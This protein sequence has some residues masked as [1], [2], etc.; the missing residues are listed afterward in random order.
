[1]YTCSRLIHEWIHYFYITV[2]TDKTLSKVYTV[3]VFTT[4]CKGE[5]YKMI[6]ET[7]QAIVNITYPHQSYL[8]DESD[9]PY[10]KD[11]CRQLGG[12]HVTRIEKIN[13]KAGNIN[14]ALRQSNGELCVVLD[15]D[16]VP[17]PDFLDPI[18]GHFSDEKVGYVQIVQAYKNYGESLVAKGAAQQTFQFYGPIMMT[19]NKYG[20]V[21]AI[22]ANCTFRRTALESIGGHA[23]GLAEDMNT[24]MHL[25][26]KGWKSLYV[27]QVL[28]RGLVPSTMSAYYSQQL[29]W[30]RGVFELLVTSYPKLFKN[31][32]WQQKIHYAVIPLYY[33]SGLVFLMNFLIPILSLIF[34][35]SPINI[36]FLYFMLY[37]GP[38]ALLSFLIRLFV[39]RWVMEEEERGFHVVGGLLMIGTWWIF[40]IGLYYTILR[41]KVPYNPTPKD[42]KEE[43]SWSINIPNISIIVLT[44]AAII[45]GLNSDWNPYNLIMS[46]FG[47]VNC[48]ILSFSILAS[49]QAGFRKIKESKPVLNTIMSGLSEFK[50]RFWLTRRFLY[51][52]IR[53]SALLIA[54]LIAACIGF[55]SFKNNFISEKVTIPN[56]NKNILIPGIFLPDNTNGLSSVK[57]INEQ[58][59]KSKLNF[60]IVSLYLSWGDAEK[61][62]VPRQLIDSIYQKKSIP[63]IT[64]E[65]WQSLFNNS[66]NL[67]AEIIE[68]KIFKR[69]LEHKFDT[70]LADFAAQIKNINKPIFIRFAHETDNP[71]YP[72][73]AT[74]SNTPA[75]FKQAWAYIHQ[76][77]AKENVNNVIWVW[78]PWKAEAID[79]YFPGNNVVDWIGV[80]NLNYGTSDKSSYS[81][82]QLYLPF[83][84]NK[85]FRTGLPVML[86][87]MGSLHK[88][89]QSDWFNQTTQ[90]LKN[91]FP[92]IKAY[93]LF[94]SSVDMNLPNGW[95]GDKLNWQ[96]ENFN[97][98]T[99]LTKLENKRSNWIL[100][101]YNVDKPHQNRITT[102]NNKNLKFL[103]QIRGINYK[104]NQ[105]WFS[106]GIV[107]KK[108][109]IIEDLTEIKKIGFNTIKFYGLT[110]YD[111][112]I[113]KAADD[114]N[115]KVVMGYW[116][117]EN[118]SFIGDSLEM[119]NLADE[120]FKSIK[121]HKDNSN[122]IMWNIANNPMKSLRFKN[123]KPDLYTEQQAYF[124]WLNTL[125]KRIKTIDS[126]P[127]SAD[128]YVD[129]HLEEDYNKFAQAITDIDCIGVV[130]EERQKMEEK[131]PEVE[132]FLSSITL[133]SYLADKNIATGFFISRWQEE[134][135][136]NFISFNGLK[137]NT[138]KFKVEAYQL[139]NQL[140]N[141]NQKIEI[142]LTKI[143]LP[144]T[145]MWPKS[146][147]TFNA[148]IFENG[149]WKLSDE[150]SILKFRWEII[151]Y[152]QFKNPIEVK[153]AG[154]GTNGNITVPDDPENYRIRLYVYNDKM[155][156]IVDSQLNIRLKRK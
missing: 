22:G 72:W 156:R 35:T 146:Q 50:K 32:T 115:L 148:L 23:A 142:P 89:K 147:V 84:Q 18:V 135:T 29:K 62:K 118:V 49:R 83:H 75:E 126:R 20:T 17:Q 42:G 112:T 125:I 102:K 53:R 6:E 34:N 30:S 7:L 41:K 9:A 114:K 121:E 98:F 92:E 104:K 99:E 124:V 68:Q 36:D 45:Y 131:L 100:F 13:A 132:S 38:L 152:D 76:F 1:M 44:I 136:T 139:A 88:A 154:T 122:I 58:E 46:G 110:I 65:P 11:L 133:E 61:C 40:L 26:A 93:I 80:T 120:I 140:T 33:L 141:G 108:R 56:Y 85:I 134:K 145:T 60:G 19:M 95:T 81:M 109:D 155:V 153:D 69:I 113:L 94:D 116:V 15:P 31:F 107:L 16:H 3:D 96:I 144:A 51:K 143:L 28:A 119:Q 67:K 117:P 4:F 129:E 150:K 14:N 57:K 149:Q 12:H 78:N 55:W 71:L 5:P 128:I 8:C 101:N 25:H 66:S 106:N 37:A 105:N 73:S 138:D 123:F 103:N 79:E 90:T 24:A 64:W 91:K 74:G 2:P 151:K 21:L 52:Q 70:Y 54:T 127:L 10:L 48:L 87:E 111:K 63:M 77:F 59:N 130:E 43:T 86:A 97:S 27:P 39:Q 137:D 82:E 47:L